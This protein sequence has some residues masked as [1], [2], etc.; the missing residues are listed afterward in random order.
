MSLD[1]LWI[2]ILPG[3]VKKNF[4]FYQFSHCP[5]CD[6]HIIIWLENITNDITKDIAKL[7][8]HLIELLILL[9]F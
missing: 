6:F 9:F 1:I 8:P 5:R 3:T 7:G 4:I 2:I